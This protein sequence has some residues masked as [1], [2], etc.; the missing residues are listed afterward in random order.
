MRVYLYLSLF[1]SLMLYSFLCRYFVH[2]SLD[3]FLSILH[4]LIK[5]QMVSFCSIFCLLYAEILLKWLIKA[6]SL[7]VMDYLLMQSCHL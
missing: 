6:N 2:L 7:P 4:V 3:L 1:L 5:L